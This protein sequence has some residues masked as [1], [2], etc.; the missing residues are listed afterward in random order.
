M[1]PSST[2]SEECSTE[3]SSGSSFK[4]VA[5]QAP[6]RHAMKSAKNLVNDQVV[7]Q[8]PWVQT[9][10]QRLATCSLQAVNFG[11]YPLSRA[12]FLYRFVPRWAKFLYEFGVK[13]YPKFGVYAV[14][15]G[16]DRGRI[17]RII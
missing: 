4:P 12:K 16:K 15:K 2:I 1:R 11:V 10:S 9:T 8:M 7:L 6:S 5:G 14:H 3:A 17:I 13:T